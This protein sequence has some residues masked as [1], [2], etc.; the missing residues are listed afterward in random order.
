MRRGASLEPMTGGLGGD[1][2]AA[3]RRGR[4]AADDEP[5]VLPP[6]A[7]V[8]LR[9]STFVVADAAG[10]IDGEPLGIFSRDTRVLSTFVLRINGQRLRNVSHIQSHT[11]QISYALTNA[12]A[13]SLPARRLSITRDRAVVDVILERL[14]VRSHLPEAVDLDLTLDVDADLLDLFEVKG[15]SSERHRVVTITGASGEERLRFTYADGGFDASVSLGGELDLRRDRNR[16]VLPVHLEAGAEWSGEI[17]IR[18]VVHGHGAARPPTGAE[19]L[20]MR[21]DAV[22]DADRWRRRWPNLVTPS[23]EF[24]ALFDRSIR[25]LAALRLRIDGHAKLDVFAA[26]LPWFMALFGRDALIAAYEVLL[27]AP[28]IARDTLV[29]LAAHQGSRFTAFTDEEPG[30]IPHELRHGELTVRHTAPHGPYYGSLDATPLWLVLWS[31]YSHITGDLVTAR[32]LLPHALRAIEWIE[33]AMGGPHAPLL[34][35]RTKSPSGLPHQSWKDSR[36]P[37]V[38]SDGRTAEAPIAPCEVQGYAIDALKRSA[39]LLRTLGADLAVA[40]RCVRNADAISVAL[41]ERLWSSERGWYVMGLDRRD[42][43]IDALASNMGHLLW[44]DAVPAHRI[45]AVRDALLSPPLAS[46]WG[47]RTLASDERAF[48]PLGY[49][50]GAVWPH[51]STLIAGGL[52]RAGYPADAAE[53]VDRL[54]RTARHFGHRLPEALAGYARNEGRDPVRYPTACSPQA[55]SAAAPMEWLRTGLGLTT[56]GGVLVSDGAMPF[57]PVHDLELHGVRAGGRRWT[58]KAERGQ[59]HVEPVSR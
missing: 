2:A 44:S 42:R 53:I 31:E 46:G 32:D 38:F 18:P 50:T 25:D 34:S 58:V 24:T 20:R 43:Q 41:D 7:T 33:V 17:W 22:E 39:D 29:A 5:T 8:A 45:G 14:T 1:D 26:G 30:K 9:G 12:Q 51:D 21:R 6:G 36:D 37:M 11:H 48:D 40:E 27:F 59:V 3:D 16:L 4:R 23:R 47:I 49:H 55:W 57:D 19:R 28:S 54:L 10:D 15:G 52:R 56:R 13:G 35:Y